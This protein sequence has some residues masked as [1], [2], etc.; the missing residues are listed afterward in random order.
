M[1]SVSADPGL[2]SPTL[3]R[4]RPKSPDSA[5]PESAPP[6]SSAS[7]HEESPKSRSR[8]PRSPESVPSPSSA[9]KEDRPA[10]EM[11]IE[12]PPLAHSV[13]SQ[14]SQSK[15]TQH[16]SKYDLNRDGKLDAVEEAIMKYD[17]NGDG[18]FS[19]TEVKGIINDLHVTEEQHRQT[20]KVACVLFV[21]LLAVCVMNFLTTMWS[22]SLMK[23][24]EQRDS[25]VMTVAGT[26]TV[27][28]VASSDMQIGADGS[29]VSRA[30]SGLIVTGTN[31]DDGVRWNT[32][33]TNLGA[34]INSPD[35]TPV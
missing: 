15:L 22:I 7:L 4:P 25:G 35:M 16:E 5:P 31:E 1:Y 6:A 23:D 32:A 28:Q 10:K 8:R 33:V 11:S 3:S 12:A 24:V 26:D 18:T 34:A 13:N 30:G 29:L 9:T 21:A 20:Q 14:Q 19:V 2:A 17:T 27:V